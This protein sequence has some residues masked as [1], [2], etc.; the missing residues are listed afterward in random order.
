[1]KRILLGIAIGITVITT[2]SMTISGAKNDNRFGGNSGVMLTVPAKPTST[3]Y[4]GY[5][6]LNKYLQKGY[7]VQQVVTGDYNEPT[8]H[9]F[10]MVK[11]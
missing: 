8:N 10:L 11:Y 9:S 3:V 6:Q 2:L 7:Q 1:M 4:V 5:N